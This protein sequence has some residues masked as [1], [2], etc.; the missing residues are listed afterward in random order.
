MFECHCICYSGSSVSSVHPLGSAELTKPC[1]KETDYTIVHHAVWCF[2]H[3]QTVA[4]CVVQ[5]SLHYST[6]YSVILGYIIQP[7]MSSLCVGRVVF[8]FLF[9]SLRGRKMGGHSYIVTVGKQP[10]GYLDSHSI[11]ASLCK[12]LDIGIGHQGP[13]WVSCSMLGHTGWTRCL[14]CK[15]LELLLVLCT[16]DTK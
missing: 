16:E 2:V 3:A 6:Y 15:W 1:I 10:G 13:M 8:Y 9:F 11:T 12:H 4:W 14:W 7:A 5:S